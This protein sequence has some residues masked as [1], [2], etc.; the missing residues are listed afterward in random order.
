MNEQDKEFWYGLVFGFGVIV[1]MSVILVVVL[2]Q[3]GA[4]T[5]ARVARREEAQEKELI[6][7]YEQLSKQALHAQESAVTEL[8]GMRQRLESIERL[9]REVE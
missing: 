9:L 4:F 7:K 8:S 5:R 6:A 2:L 1:L 3:V